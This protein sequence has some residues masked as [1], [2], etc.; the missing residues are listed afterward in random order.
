M[1]V[2]KVTK[3]ND[4]LFA[5]LTGQS[6][7]EIF[8]RSETEFFWKVVEAHVTFVKDKSGKVIKATHHQGGQTIDAPRLPDEAG[9]K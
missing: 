9:G 5:Q 6:K 1:A 2:M 8:P 3:E 4:R 7:F